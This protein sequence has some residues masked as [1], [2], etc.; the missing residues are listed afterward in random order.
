MGNNLTG[1]SGQNQGEQQGEHVDAAIHQ[2]GQSQGVKDRK[3]H[4]NRRYQYEL[5]LLVEMDNEKQQDKEGGD[6][7]CKFRL[8]E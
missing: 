1:L 4:G 8:G 5:V 7:A 6:F 2:P 3:P